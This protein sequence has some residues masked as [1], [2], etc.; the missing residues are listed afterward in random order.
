MFKTIRSKLIAIIALIML[1][2]AAVIIYFTHRD[3]GREMMRSE[4][5]NVENVVD[6]VFLNIQGVYRGLISDRISS[7]EQSK[8]RLIRETG[9]VLSSLEF[10]I[11]GGESENIETKSFRRQQFIDWIDDLDMGS[12]DFLVADRDREVVFCSD[13]EIDGRSLNHMEDMKGRPLSE[14]INSPYASYEKF[15]VFSVNESDSEKKG[16]KLAYFTGIP[17][18]QGVLGAIVDI[19][20][21]R[22]EEKGRLQE[23][24]RELEDQFKEMRIAGSGSIFIF[25]SG[26]EIVVPPAGI[27]NIEA[28]DSHF[29]DLVRDNFDEGYESIRLDGE[30][31]IVY[32]RYFRPLDWYLSA[33]IPESEIQAPAE[34]L[35]QRQSLLIAGIF[36]LGVLAVVFLVRQISKP[37]GTLAHQARELAGEDLT[38]EDFDFSQI[39]K[40]TEKHRDEVGALAAAFLYM[41]E[42]LRKNVRRL[43]ESTRATERI[44]SELEVARNI[45]MNFLPRVFPPFPGRRD[46]D[47][48]ATLEPARHVGGDFYDFY[49]LDEDHLF[50]SIGDVSDKGVPAALFMAVTKTLMKGIT[51]QG[52]EPSEI[53]ARVNNE[54][55]QG[56]DS[57]MFVTL[58]CGILNL[59]TGELRYTNAGHNPPVLI[60]AG[61]SAQ[62][63]DLP[64]G[65]VLGGIED[66]VYQTRSLYLSADDKLL[67]YTDGV[68]E[69]MN[70]QQELFSDAR[71]LRETRAGAQAGPGELVNGI[72]ETVH[73]FSR[74]AP[75]SDDITMMAVLYNGPLE[76]QN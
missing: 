6:M 47:I 58:F 29:P 26:N 48:F 25:D 45:Q 37:L 53:L 23:L 50:F 40:L 8:E 75:Q 20:H 61:Q 18:W 51:E 67:M 15:A 56:N 4:Q 41:Q 22:D 60:R 11:P 28:L 59:G 5:Q 52:H 16:G 55:C 1:L 19:S 12:T 34:K 17:R 64:S 71:L 46:F 68:T 21:I 24:T 3:V 74:G 38:S 72:I 57:C 7:I 13:Q 31:M 30:N 70:P 2:T 42:E 10:S 73:S 43:L 69:A 54:L 39:S 62:W 63:L 76:E 33:L 49:L 66:A 36:F 32:T 35:I 27:D 65:M 44:E 14:T 9:V